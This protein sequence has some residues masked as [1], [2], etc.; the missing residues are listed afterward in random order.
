MLTGCGGTQRLTRAVGKSKAMEMCLTGSLMDAQ[1]A[2]NRGLVSSLFKDDEVVPEAIKMA[3]AIARQ[4]KPIAQMCKEAVNAAYESSLA[5]GTRF[6]RRIF[7]STFAT[8]DRKE[9]MSAF[10]EKRKPNFIHK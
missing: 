1:E 3:N 6:E 2:Y 5:E 4:S 7:H 8:A 10:V 9:G